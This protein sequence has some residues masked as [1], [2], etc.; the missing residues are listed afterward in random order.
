MFYVDTVH[1]TEPGSSAVSTTANANGWYKILRTWWRNHQCYKADCPKGRRMSNQDGGA[2]RKPLYS[3]MSV[4][5]RPEREQR[6]SSS[7]L[8]QV[9]MRDDAWI[10]LIQSKTSWL[11][12]SSQ[13]SMLNI[14]PFQC[15][16][17]WGLKWRYR[18]IDT[19]VV[20]STRN[21]EVLESFN[22]LLY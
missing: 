19:G 8:T 13:G 16:D 3:E 11:S 20:G 4:S 9:V 2:Q 7:I 6:W 10:N 5:K 15:C 22:K 14:S 21:T 1:V 12:S 17:R 18:F